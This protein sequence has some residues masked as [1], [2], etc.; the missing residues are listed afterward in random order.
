M[1]LKNRYFF[2]RHGKNIHQEELKD[3]LYCW[4]DDNPPCNLNEEGMKQAEHAGHLLKNK[5]IEYIFCS[6]I[7]RTRQTAEIVADII[8]FDA[9]KI[10]YDTRLRDLNWGDFGGKTKEEYW[11]FYDNE[12]MR[13]FTLAVPGGESWHQ[14]LERV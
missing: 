3:I 10:I 5:K 9:N 11:N 14:C 13:C 12:R 4:P 2:L 8:G 7:L 6:D 1:N